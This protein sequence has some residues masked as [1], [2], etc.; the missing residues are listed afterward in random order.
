M[1]QLN[2]NVTMRQT[3]STRQSSAKTSIKSGLVSTETAAI[4]S[5]KDPYPPRTTKKELIA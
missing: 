4:S 2:Y 1:V 3:T 5:I